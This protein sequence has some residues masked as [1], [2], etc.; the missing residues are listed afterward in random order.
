MC[1]RTDAYAAA[2]LHHHLCTLAD[3]D[4]PAP[5]HPPAR[6]GAG[7]ASG[8]HLR[9]NAMRGLHWTRMLLQAKALTTAADW[10][11]AYAELAKEKDVLAKDKN[12]L[13]KE[14]D[15]LASVAK[16]KDA[17][18]AVLTKEKEVLAK[19][20]SQC[21]ALANSTGL[22]GALVALVCEALS[23]RSARSFCA[24]RCVCDVCSGSGGRRRSRDAAEASSRCRCRARA[25]TR[26]PCELDLRACGNVPRAGFVL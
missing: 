1:L 14:K 2:M 19:Q 5:S 21:T 9:T 25:E 17:Q 22:F 20:L 12:V 7:S 23:L 18:L 8:A 11:Q 3:A 16:E 24:D 4:L 26:A 15:A 10:A 6:T 13:V